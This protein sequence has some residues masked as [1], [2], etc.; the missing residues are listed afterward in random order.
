MRAPVPLRKREPVEP[1]P[2][3]STV[4]RVQIAAALGTDGKLAE[5]SVLGTVSQALKQA[6]I[7]DA[8]AWEFKPATR[9]GTPVAVELV[10]EIPFSLPAVVTSSAP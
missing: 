7:Q 9:E 8:M 10:L 2:S 5:I 3:S 1:P 4:T 6:A